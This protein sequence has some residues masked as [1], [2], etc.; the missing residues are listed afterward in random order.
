M[1]LVEYTNKV[2]TFK[3]TDLIAQLQVLQ[4]GMRDLNDNLGRIK[5]VMPDFNTLAEKWAVTKSI[6]TAAR[7]N[8]TLPNSYQFSDLLD[9]SITASLYLIPELEKAVKGYSSKIWDGK[10]L[11]MRQANILNVIEYLSFWLKYSAVVCDVLVTQHNQSIAPEQY[12]SKADLRWVNG[13]REFYTDFSKDLSEGSRAI[14]KR[15][16]NIPDVEVDEATVEIVESSHGVD[17]AHL[18]KRGFG[19]HTVNPMFWVDV[20]KSKY[21]IYRIEQMRDQNMTLAMKINQAAN[22]KN[23]TNDAALD[24]QIEI[25]QDKIILNQNNI[26]QIEARYA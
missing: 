3:E 11:T 19:I 22:K 8:G 24:R 6:L 18:V 16:D 7:R 1:K 9:H 20:V 14:M 25:Y 5:D 17:K 2:K 13:T 23:G 4:V 10:I 15:L 12:M 26:E 21:N